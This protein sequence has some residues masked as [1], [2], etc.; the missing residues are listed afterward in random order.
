MVTE[1]DVET[2]GKPEQK[3]TAKPLIIMDLDYAAFDGRRVVFKAA[4]AALKAAGTELT[5]PQFSRI[6]LI[7][8]PVYIAEALAEFAGN[9]K[10]DAEELGVT[11]QDAM[12]E[13]FRSGKVK[14]SEKTQALLDAAK[15][16]GVDLAAFTTLPEDIATAAL[17][18]A[19]LPADAIEIAA[20]PDCDKHFPRVDT[21]LK[22]CR[23]QSKTSRSCVAVA[24]GQEAA[25]TALAAGMRCVVIPDDFTAF[26][27]FGGADA[28]I[29]SLDDA[30]FKKLLADI[31]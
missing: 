22:I 14:F 28:V 12:H 5:Q 27:D 17:E 4:Q 9:E 29:D 8:H 13:A 2:A 7:A 6:A 26:Q 16:L 25:K 3:V 1:A 15:P 11:L 24:A 31:L 23:G 20:Y 18:K 19:G 10:V 30:D 21:W